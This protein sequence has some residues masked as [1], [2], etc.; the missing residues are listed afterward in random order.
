MA[1]KTPKIKHRVRVEVTDGKWIYPSSRYSKDNIHEFTKGGYDD[2]SVYIHLV[3]PKKVGEVKEYTVTVEHLGERQYK[4]TYEQRAKAMVRNEK[5][6]EEWKKQQALE[7]LQRQ[8]TELV[9][10]RKR[11]VNQIE[12][13][14]VKQVRGAVDFITCDKC[15][16]EAAHLGLKHT[17]PGSQVID[18]DQITGAWCESHHGQNHTYN[19]QTRFITGYRPY[20]TKASIACNTLEFFF[21]GLRQICVKTGEAA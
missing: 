1:T 10:R 9:Q 7:E 14:F 16:A 8:E 17:N 15:N 13:A 21:D 3:V 18:S 12:L 2:S 11:I 19:G 4:Q 20:K 6:S 5:R